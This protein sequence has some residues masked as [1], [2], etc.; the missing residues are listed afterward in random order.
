MSTYAPPFTDALSILRS[1]L[2]DLVAALDIPFHD[3][4]PRSAGQTPLIY[5]APPSLSYDDLDHLIDVAWPLVLVQHT[6]D[7]EAS[8]R[9]AD[10]L[11]W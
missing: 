3:T 1:D 11:V 6:I 5:M 7:T 10:G 8:Q 9:D 4:E 2:S